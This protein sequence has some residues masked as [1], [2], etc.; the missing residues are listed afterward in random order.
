[1]ARRLDLG[2]IPQSKGGSCCTGSLSLEYAA[3]NA[4]MQVC[5]RVQEASLLSSKGITRQRASQQLLLQRIASFIAACSVSDTSNGCSSGLDAVELEKRGTVLPAKR[6]L[7][8]G[9]TLS[10]LE[11]WT[12]QQQSVNVQAEAG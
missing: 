9:S 2:D 3:T 11:G 6:L 8:D 5:G 12:N 10:R 4:R 7:F 1:M